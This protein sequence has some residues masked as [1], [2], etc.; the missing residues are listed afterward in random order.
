[1]KSLVFPEWNADAAASEATNDLF[2]SYHDL[3]I[4]STFD[5]L[6][7]NARHLILVVATQAAKL[8]FLYETI[9]NLESERVLPL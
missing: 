2:T 9:C 8:A 7:T 1:M 3:F 6:E 5:D 4:R